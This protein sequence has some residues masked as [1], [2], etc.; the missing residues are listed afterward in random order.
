M[1]C[2]EDK[3]CLVPRPA[4]G[5]GKA[6]GGH[7]TSPA[8]WKRANSGRFHERG[9]TRVRS[10]RN[11]TPVIS[12][13]APQVFRPVGYLAAEARPAIPARLRSNPQTDDGVFKS[14]AVP[15]GV[16]GRF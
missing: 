10:N 2:R 12:Q 16:G 15:K 1:T 4:S 14:W 9:E 13:Q 11:R 8:P 5:L 6:A 7:R 3:G